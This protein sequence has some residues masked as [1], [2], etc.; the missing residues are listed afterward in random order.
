MVR[1]KYSCPFV[2]VVLQFVTLITDNCV[3][4]AKTQGISYAGAK[5]FRSELNLLQFILVVTK[6]S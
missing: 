4:L 2:L 1:S 5:H 3:L 6:R